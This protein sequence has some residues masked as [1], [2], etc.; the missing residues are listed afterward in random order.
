[1]FGPFSPGHFVKDI[2][3]GSPAERVGL[4]DMDRLVAVNG[5]GVDGLSHEQVVER[6]RQCGDRCSLL[7]VDTETD[8]MYKLVSHHFEKNVHILSTVDTI[9]W[10]TV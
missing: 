6:I 7:V 9:H 10:N 1:M 4:R 8:K 2:D 3:R 5:D